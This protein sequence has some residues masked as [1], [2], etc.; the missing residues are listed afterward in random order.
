PLDAPFLNEYVLPPVPPH[1]QSPVRRIP[2]NDPARH[3]ESGRLEFGPRNSIHDGA[4]SVFFVEG[5][6]EDDDM[7]PGITRRGPA[8]VRPRNLGVAI[9]QGVR[10]LGHH[11]RPHGAGLLTVFVSSVTAPIRANA[12]PSSVAPVFSVMD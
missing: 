7:A 12:L 5:R 4:D 2:V 9:P 1:L 8:R 11:F 6:Q 10:D 3:G